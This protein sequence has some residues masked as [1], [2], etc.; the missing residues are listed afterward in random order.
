M[1]D[2]KAWLDRH[3]LGRHHAHLVENGI[4]MDI[5]GDLTDADLASLDLNLGDRR[6]LMLAIATLDRPA[7]EPAETPSVGM[8][9]D[10]AERRQITLVFIDLVGSTQLSNTLDLDAYHDALNGYLKAC[11]KTIR[12]RD[13]HLA[14]LI[15]DGVVGYFGYPSAREDDAERAVLAGLEACRAIRELPAPAGVPLEVRV[16]ISTGDVIV[17]ARMEDRGLA[18]G[19]VPNL[20]ARLQAFADPGTVA[21]SDRTRQLLG[22]NF[23]CAWRGEHRLAGFEAPVGVWSVLD[24]EE[25]VLRFEAQQGDD[26]TPIVDRIEELRLL[27]DRWNETTETVGQLVMLSGEA[28]IGKSRL[29]KAL[30]DWIGPEGCMRLNFQCSA[31][32]GQSAFHPVV[33]F[34]SGT[35]GI[36]RADSQAEKRHKLATLIEAW[37]GA[38]TDVLPILNDLLSI[39]PPPGQ[40]LEP[41]RPEEVK[42][43]LRE[44]LVDLVGGLAADKPVLLLFEDLHWI[45]PSSEELLDALIEE[46]SSARV[47]IV[48]TYRPDYEDRWAER[49][50]ATTL[51]IARLDTYYSHEMVH[52]MLRESALS[53]KLERRI[54]AKTDGVPL[55]I[56]EMVRMVEG[57]IE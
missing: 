32:Y 26:V 28:G 18:L 12:G 43:R 56:E 52:T 48:C 35:A 34:L 49:V 44:L 16:G 22:R 5:V 10:E 17:D 14:L 47:L 21:V 15:G 30:A 54:V 24:V 4:D 46:L 33:S 55:F 23:D 38:T 19:E 53:R 40:D 7:D 45:D 9:R 8:M 13:G 31:S 1:L 6:R 51:S 29:L 20:A 25:A 2:L 27:Q 39:P 57:R 36:K 41:I 37:P 11:A 50:R 42:I 3:S